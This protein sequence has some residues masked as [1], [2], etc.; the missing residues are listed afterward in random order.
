M[1]EFD[2][3]GIINRR[4]APAGGAKSAIRQALAAA[5]EHLRMEIAY[6]SEFVDGNSVF[7]EVDAP[8]LEHLAKPGDA[9]RLQ[10]VYCPHILEGRLP[11]RIPD[12]SLIPLARD[13]PITA[14]APIGAHMSVPIRLPNGRCYG[15]FCCLSTRPDPSLS[16]RD[17]DVMR[18][19]AALAGHQIAN[20][21][22]AE[23]FVADRRQIILDTISAG[24]FRTVLQPIWD[25]NAP[26]I[27]AFECLTRFSAEPYRS[28]DVWF[29]EADS[30]GLGSALE[31]AALKSALA[32]LPRLAPEAYVS[33]NLSPA[34][35]T[36]APIWDAFAGADL[37]RVVLEVTEHARFDDHQALLRTLQPLR[38]RG[39]K[40]AIDDAGAGYSGL[41]RIVELKPDMIKLDISLTRNVDTSPAL[42]ALSSALIFFARETGCEV[43]AEGI[44]T[45]GELATLRTLGVSKGQGYLLGRP[46]ELSVA[47]QMLARHPRAA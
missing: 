47:S 28:P 19:F 14:A 17:L 44:E 23:E 32:V 10:D 12:T 15:M 46:V 21:L 4:A 42:R 33:V 2:L 6:V 20:D 37:S 24:T 30:V 39:L 22:A 13:L 29:G 18:A 41:Q 1:S 36:G 34:V 35:I 26:R 16:E 40:L 43:V 11:E 3:A 7:R 25:I 27:A 45:Q 38:R 9:H 5:R 31:L 8:G